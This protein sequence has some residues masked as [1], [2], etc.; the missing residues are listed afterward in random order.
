MRPG[1]NMRTI[2]ATAF[3]ALLAIMAFAFIA[4]IAVGG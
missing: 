3:I 1:F 2:I 4:Q